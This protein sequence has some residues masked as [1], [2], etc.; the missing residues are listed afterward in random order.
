VTDPVL[1]AAARFERDRRC[2]S[3]PQAIFDGRVTAEQAQVDYQAW[4][5]IAQWLETGEFRI[6]EEGG[7]DGATRI[8]WAVCEAAA[9]KALK[10]IERKLAGEGWFDGCPETATS[11]RRCALIRIHRKVQLRRQSIDAINAEFRANKHH[12]EGISA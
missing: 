8:D 6:I 12:R 4:C 10:K 7:A 2:E 1:A 5:L 9:D 3:A 11:Q